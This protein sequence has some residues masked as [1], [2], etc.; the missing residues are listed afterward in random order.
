[1]SR[2]RDAIVDA[3]AGRDGEDVRELVGSARTVVLVEGVS[4]VAALEHLAVRR[5]RDL[6]AERVCVVPMG[7]A[8]SVGRFVELLAP[9]GVRMAG[10]SDRGEWQFYVR[11][12]DR[13][14]LGTDGFF[15]CD[16]DLEH[17]LIRALGVAGV[18]RVIDDQG[19][20]ATLRTFQRQPAQRP[21]SAEHQL[22]RWFG[23]IGGR[24]ERY[25]GALVDALDLDRVP[26]PLDDLLAY[27]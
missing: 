12:L 24:K 3:A 10:L 23:S 16:A 22:H 21:R 20:L 13:A 19:D 9:R 1:M 4:D 26:R 27:A 18:E 7:G 17:E 14:G 8:T 15:V 6:H 25:A 2:L 11:A 5:A